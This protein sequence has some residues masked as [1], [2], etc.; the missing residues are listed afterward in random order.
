MTW[1][2]FQRTSA[3]R[4]RGSG[5]APPALTIH[6]R[7]IISVNGPAMDLAFGDEDRSSRLNVELLYDAELRL[8]G[9]RQADAENLNPHHLRRQGKSRVYLVSAVQFLAHYGIGHPVTLRYRATLLG[10]I[11]SLCLDDQPTIASRKQA[12]KASN[13]EGEGSRTRRGSELA[14]VRRLRAREEAS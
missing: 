13:G 8:I 11:L 4:G 5:P 3:G 6:E 9:I 14:M 2:V 12:P 10:D 7:G 1:Q